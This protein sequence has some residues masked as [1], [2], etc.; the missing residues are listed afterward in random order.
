MYGPNDDV[1]VADLY[2]RVGAVPDLTSVTFDCTSANIGSTEE[3][4]TLPLMSDDTVYASLHAYVGF[5]A[6]P[7]PVL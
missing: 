7:S 4:S 6:S 3:C 2:V 5:L 1:G